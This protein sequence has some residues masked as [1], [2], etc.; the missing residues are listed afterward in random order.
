MQ[1]LAG[2]RWV[3]CALS[4]V[5]ILLLIAIMGTLWACGLVFPSR[6]RYVLRATAQCREMFVAMVESHRALVPPASQ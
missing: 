5:P 4:V 1:M 6:R 3:W 2:G